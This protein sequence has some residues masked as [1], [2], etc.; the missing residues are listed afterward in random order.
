[1]RATYVLVAASVVLL[2]G[3]ASAQ[4]PPPKPPAKPTKIDVG[5]PVQKLKSG[6]EEQIRSALDELRLAGTGAAAAAPAIGDLL[7]A[8]LSEPLS[9]QAIDTLA[10]LESPEGSRAVSIYANHRILPLR[11]A[12]VRALTRTRGPAA[13][14]PLR[15]ALGDP[16]PQIR[17]TAAAGLGAVKAKDA[18]PDLFTALDHKVN[19]AASAIGQL[20]T[21]DQCE[22]LASSLGRLPFEVVT[23]GLDQVLFR[24][25]AEVSDDTKIK[26]LG[27]LRE[28]GTAEA[29]RFLKDV[30]KRLPKETS[31]RVR[32]T[33]DQAVKATSGGTQ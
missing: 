30:A 2:A 19:E 1:M 12:A 8:G 17:S 7:E 29:N 24:P 10:D 25:V 4:K 31:A 32:Q 27:R 21:A 18:V 3:A 16:D 13:V 11:R 15:H 28:L 5:P 23:S 26:V 33:V 14:A 22:Q 6:S 9:L 20:C